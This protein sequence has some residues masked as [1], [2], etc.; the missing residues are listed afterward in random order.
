M[1]RSD[2]HDVRVDRRG[3]DDR[4]VLARRHAGDIQAR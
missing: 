3:V 4:A 2:I 1:G